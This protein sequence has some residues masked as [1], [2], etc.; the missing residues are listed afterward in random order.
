MPS[1]GVATPLRGVFAPSEISSR[2]RRS[3]VQHWL[4]GA[5]SDETPL[6]CAANAISGERPIEQTPPRRSSYVKQLSPPLPP[7]PRRVEQNY[8][9]PILA[10]LMYFMS[11]RRVEQRHNERFQRAGATGGRQVNSRRFLQQRV[12]IQRMREHPNAPV[13]RARPLLSRSIPVEFHPVAVWITKVNR[14]AHAVVGSAFEPN[15]RFHDATQRICEERAR[16]IHNRDVIQPR[17]ARRRRRPALTLPRVQPDMMVIPARRDK[18]RA[19]A[20]PLSQLKPQHAAIKRQR[21]VQIRNL[22]MHVAN[23]HPRINYSAFHSADWDAQC[24]PGG[25][26]IA[27]CL[28][29][30]P[31]CGTSPTADFV[32]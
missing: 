29:S 26:H 14:L 15:P 20:H 6:S 23:P 25:S 27:A 32:D 10:A 3:R 8:R 1:A 5:E 9:F 11:G 19:L 24:L 30:S 4:H 21:P 31:S 13:R 18:R 2:V 16:R 7:P 28:C 17:R 22:Q 12:H